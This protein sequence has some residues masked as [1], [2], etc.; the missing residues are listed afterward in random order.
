[1]TGAKC[2]YV[3]L[4]LIQ[5]TLLGLLHILL[6]ASN[7]S[8]QCQPTHSIDKSMRVTANLDPGLLWRLLFLLLRRLLGGFRF[9]VEVD[10]DPE[11]VPNFV[12]LRATRADNAANVFLIDLEFGGLKEVGERQLPS[13]TLI[14]KSHV[15]N[16]YQSHH[17]W[18]SQRWL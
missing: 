12:D 8:P 13:Q 15:R 1:M 7:L 5:D 11:R 6:T 4:N 17:S 10:G 3:S 16:R 2:T 9:L 14:G 18:P